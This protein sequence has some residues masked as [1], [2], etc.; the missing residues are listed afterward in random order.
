MFK[1]KIA[2]LALAALTVT[3]GVTA[4]TSQAE[5]RRGLGVAMGIGFA[6]GAMI[7]A[8][9]ASSG[10]PVYVSDYGYRRCRLVRQYDDYGYYIGRTRVCY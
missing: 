1:T 2:A 9:A 4:T 5:A 6:T 10:G 7:G 8:A 3:A